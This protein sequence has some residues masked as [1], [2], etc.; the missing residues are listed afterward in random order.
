[1]V[2]TLPDEAARLLPSDTEEATALVTEIIFS[3]LNDLKP[4]EDDRL[5]NRPDWQ[6]AVQSGRQARTE[7]RVISHEDVLDWHNQHQ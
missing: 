6:A 2:I 7:G 4:A 5:A 1:M 3:V